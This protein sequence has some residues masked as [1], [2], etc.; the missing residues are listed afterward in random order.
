MSS[1]KEKTANDKKRS[2]KVVKLK[3]HT[4]LLG[5]L[6]TAILLSASFFIFGSHVRL[7]NSALLPYTLLFAVLG[8]FLFPFL[9]Y[10]RVV[11][12][13]SGNKISDLCKRVGFK[14]TI[15]VVVVIVG[16]LFA[17]FVAPRLIAQEDANYV[18]DVCSESGINSPECSNIQQKRSVSCSQNGL[19]IE[20]QKDYLVPFLFFYR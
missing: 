3:K 1:N 2:R 4:V 10:C 6:F 20:C 5:S 14:K 19:Y 11:F 7:N 13:D 12:I 9:N 16:M 15:L 8:L 18:A 17:V